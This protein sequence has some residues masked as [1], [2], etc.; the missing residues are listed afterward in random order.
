MTDSP[1]FPEYANLQALFDDDVD[2]LLDMPVKPPTVTVDDRVR[3][4][5]LEIV[6]FHRQH[7][8]PPR[9]DTRTSITERRLGARL[10]GLLADEDQRAALE[11]LDEFGVLAIPE[12]PAS[13]DDLL[14]GGDD[15]L[16]DGAD[17]LDVSSLPQRRAEMD[18]VAQRVKAKDFDQF[19]P[20]FKQKHAE[21]NDGTASLRTFSG[22]KNIREGAFFVLNGLMGF[23]AEAGDSDEPGGAKE[24][25][26][27]VFENGTESRMLRDSLRTRMYEERRNTGSAFLVTPTKIVEIDGDDEHSG[28]I[29]VLKSLSTEPKISGIEHLYKIG[30]T[31]G[32][33]DK[34]IAHAEDQPTYLMAP[35]QV[36]GSWRTYNLK[37]S[38]LEALIH[39]VFADV[40]LQL[41][42]VDKHGMFQTPTEWYVVP[43]TVIEDAVEKIVSGDIV[44]YVYDSTA[45]SLVRTTI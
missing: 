24:R 16:D 21:I 8:R 15:L 38:T 45:K 31:K 10:D 7:G 28:Y 30:Y 39:R 18:E 2:G 5:F 37:T 14:A 12:P 32:T 35:V 29:Y 41:Q 42:V 13:L 19:E 17:I 33:V 26:R 44:N 6:E 9:S 11:P 1:D 43:Y 27:V 23:I 36:V 34:R 3:A 22:S 20:L 4:G 40:K 25:L